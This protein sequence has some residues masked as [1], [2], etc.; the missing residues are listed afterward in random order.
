MGSTSHSLSVL[1]A[2]ISGLR[3]CLQPL[4]LLLRKPE[5]LFVAALGMM[6]LRAPDLSNCWVDRAAFVVL[7][8]V[9]LMRAVLLRQTLQPA[10]TIFWSMIGM[11]ALILVD[12]LSSPYDVQLWS[13]AA[14]KFFVPYA[15]FFLA[16]LVFDDDSTL[17]SFEVFA[18]WPCQVDPLKIIK[19]A[20]WATRQDLPVAVGLGFTGVEVFWRTGR[21]VR[22]GN[23]PSGTIVAPKLINHPNECD[24]RPVG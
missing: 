8:V 15:L 11:G 12:L 23:E 7:T 3:T 18:V 6:L 17:R 1:D 19:G 13:V 14:A 16:G 24:Q 5:W 9:V 4:E 22:A 2:G 21:P 10:S 20:R